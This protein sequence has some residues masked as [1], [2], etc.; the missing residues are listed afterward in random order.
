MGT[1]G[2]RRK[3]LEPAFATMAITDGRGDARVFATYS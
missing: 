2:L 1:K 3:L